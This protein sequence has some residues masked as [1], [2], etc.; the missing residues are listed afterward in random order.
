[1]N[2]QPSSSDNKVYNEYLRSVVRF[3]S[4]PSRSGFSN[5][6]LPAGG[7]GSTQTQPQ[8]LANPKAAGANLTKTLDDAVKG[9]I[10]AG[11]P[12]E[13]VSFSLA[14]VSTDQKSPG[15]PIWEYHHLAEKN[16]LGTKNVTRDSQYLIG[17]VSKVI[18]DYILLKSGVNIDR[19]V[20]DFIPKL[21]SSKSKVHWKDVTL[22]MLGSQLSG[23]PTNGEYSLA[24]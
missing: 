15:V 5:P 17:S 23:A 13:N 1:M 4:I 10:K 9:V 19:P 24:Q 22:R 20:T 7:T 16:E 11:W 21:K 8:Q 2:P 6:Q 12:V 18:S 14:V 3:A